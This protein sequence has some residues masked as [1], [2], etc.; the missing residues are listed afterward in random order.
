MLPSKYLK[1]L[2]KRLQ[3]IKRD[4]EVID[5]SCRGSPEACMAIK[6]CI[7]V[8]LIDSLITLYRVGEDAAH[9]RDYAVWVFGSNLRPGDWRAWADIGRSLNELVAIVTKKYGRVP[10][11][12]VP[13]K[14][15]LMD[16]PLKF[17][18]AIPHGALQEGIPV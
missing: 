4:L 11:D 10:Y 9:E 13:Y 17:R 18:D 6:E 7:P 5:R 12:C 1:N 14:H 15:L 16:V 8:R 3:R 2:R